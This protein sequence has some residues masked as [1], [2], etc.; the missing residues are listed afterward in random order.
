MLKPKLD[1]Y[2][3]GVVAIMAETPSRS[4]VGLDFTSIS[5][6]DR[7]RSMAF[8]QMSRR[9]EDMK[10]ADDDG[11]SLTLK[12]KT[13]HA[14]D[15]TPEHLALVGTSLFEVGHVD[16]DRAHDFLYL[17]QLRSD[18]TIDLCS[19]TEKVGAHGI[20]TQEWVKQ[21]VHVRKATRQLLS[22]FEAH[23]ETMQPNATFVIRS[24][25]YSDQP[26]IERGGV[27][28]AVTKTES[29]G[30]WMLLTCQVGANGDG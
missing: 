29:D 6:L 21:T 25:D 9:A 27:E 4:T 18:G 10:L 28:M 12:L 5:G 13:R 15:V 7:V 17:S 30:R 1:V 19:K 26:R 16:D 8:C 11:F 24:C 2:A 23:Q 14:A 3:D 22:H 20:V